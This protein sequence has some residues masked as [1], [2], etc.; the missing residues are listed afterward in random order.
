M[1]LRPYQ[2]ECIDSIPESGSYLIQ[3][4]TGL[5]KTVTFSQVPRRGRVLILSHR[6]E[7]V[8]QPSKYYSCS[9]GIEQ[10]KY[11]SDGEE[12]ISASVQSLKNRLERFSPD[13]FDIIITDEAHH[14]AA[15]TYKKIYAHFNPRLHLGFTATPNRSDNVRLDDIFEKIIFE[16]DLV[17]GIKNKYLCDLETLRVDIGYDLSRVTIRLGDYAQGELSEA[18]NTFKIN[19]ALVDT[20]NKY[21]LNQTVIFACSV[22]HAKSISELIPSSAVIHAGTKNRGEILDAFRG[23]NIRTI[24]NCMVLTEG[25]DLPMLETIMIAR[26][27][28]SSSLYTQMVGRVLRNHPGK[29]KA[30]LIDLVGNTGRVDIC[31]APTLLGIDLASVPAKAREQIKGD[32]FDLPDIIS[33][34]SDCPESWIKNVEIVDLWAKENSYHT[35]NVNY[36]KMPNGDMVVSLKDRKYIRVTA[37]DQ[38]GNSRVVTRIG[39]SEQMKTQDAFDRVFTMLRDHAMDQEYIW[40]MSKVKR[41]GHQAASDKQKAL[42]E[43]MGII[44]PNL[45]KLEAASIL[46]RKFARY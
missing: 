43:R 4:A 33:R 17:W 29:E 20:Y 40:N 7:L 5:G 34:I 16:R 18:M 28:K 31:T 19:E 23:G 41:W 11:K 10:G 37:S 21:A 13:H 15:E 12:I 32:L 42:V 3:M 25:T 14:A 24:V 27:T 2:Q 6:E 30:R 9:F 45:T 46:N 36:F 26:P 35:H 8:K 38:L 22:D 44:M 1:K 39:S